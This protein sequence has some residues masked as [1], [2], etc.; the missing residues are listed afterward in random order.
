MK[1][2]LLLSTVIFT[3]SFAAEIENKGTLIEDGKPSVLV[4]HEEK[5][6]WPFSGPFKN[7]FIKP[8]EFENGKFYCG[9]R[10]TYT[11][12]KNPVLALIEISAD[13]SSY[14]E[15]IKGLT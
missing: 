3:T 5:T 13:G 11:F 14:K 10:T 2:L 12:D 9:G 4:T 8:G 6:V 1:K 15:K 7:Q